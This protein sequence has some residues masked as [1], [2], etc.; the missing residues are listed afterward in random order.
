MRLYKLD[1]P[2]ADWHE[3]RQADTASV[4]RNYIKYGIDL[5][6]PTYG[7]LSN[8]Q[9]GKDNPK[10]YRFVEFPI[11][12]GLHAL[13]VQ[14]SGLTIEKAGRLLSVILS[15]VGL[16]GMWFLARLIW[17]DLTA[18]L[19][20]GFASVNAYW[21]YYSRVILPEPL[22]ITSATWAL[23][24]LVRYIF[25]NEKKSVL[26]GGVLLSIALLVKPFIIVWF[27][28][29]P[30]FIISKRKWKQLIILTFIFVTALLPF[31]LWRWWIQ[32]F[33][34]GIPASRW[35]FNG[36]GIRF[37]PAF[38]RWLFYE[39]ISKL[40]LG[41]WGVAA[42]II[43]LAKKISDK[44]T[45]IY[46]MLI[47]SIV[48][49]FVIATG[50]VRHDYYQILL[51]PAL[52]FFVGRG[53]KELITGTWVNKKTA[54]LIACGVF[55]GSNVFGWYEIKGYYQINHPE[56]IEAGQHADKILPKSA[57]V[58]APYFG[59]TAFLYQTNRPGWPLGYGIE[60][61]INK[62]A[63]AYVS[64]NFDQETQEL[65]QKYKVLIKTPK[66]VIINLKE[67]PTTPSY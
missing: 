11:Y 67:I 13:L 9:S 32:Q 1:N 42:L 43:G 10:G 59:D 60:D 33:P 38:F 18:I 54:W 5:L 47:G 40:I 19:I 26:A 62:G 24:F 63:T 20:I 2:I 36:D 65:M 16:L 12:N 52:A 6:K 57:K 8:I 49:L 48:Y 45:V 34:E 28:G 27:I 3:F 44:G 58:I 29:L 35:L 15:V 17:D 7:D 39:R 46:G 53:L 64:V 23:Y 4:S 21:V 66:Y 51:F 56:I 22:M 14:V 25:F 61:K 55:F 41:G 37:R 50:N 31:L 30:L